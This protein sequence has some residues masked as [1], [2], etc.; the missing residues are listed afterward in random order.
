LDGLCATGHL[1][2]AAQR[3]ELTAQFGG[4]VSQPGHVGGR[5]IQL[6]QRLFL[7]LAVLED[8][9]GFLDERPAVLRTRFQDLRQPA[10]ADDDVH[11]PADTGVAE[12]LL[13]VEQPATVAVDLVLAGA[14]AEHPAGDGHLGVLDGQ[15]VIGIV[16]GQGD[17]GAA[18]RRPRGRAG[19]DDVLHLAAAQGFDSLLAH[20]PGQSVDDV[21]FAGAVGTNHA[22]DARLE[23]QSR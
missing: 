8:P 9:G 20:H 18:Q 15:R 22:G 2:L 14:V 17:L 16:D 10:L 13:D 19:E 23:A 11:L 12:Q 4:E 21:G 1:G 6:A 7:A 3:L 5:G